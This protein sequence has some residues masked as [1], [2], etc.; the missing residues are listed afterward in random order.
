MSARLRPVELCLQGQVA[1]P[2]SV[3]MSRDAAR[4]LWF[5][6][7]GRTT[8]VR[9]VYVRLQQAISERSVSLAGCRG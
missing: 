8:F 3:M 7:A 9:P 2:D 6:A 5:G 1:A 4:G